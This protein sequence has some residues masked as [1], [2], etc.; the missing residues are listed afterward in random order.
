MSSG[1]RLLRP[2]GFKADPS[3]SLCQGRLRSRPAS[4]GIELACRRVITAPPP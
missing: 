1:A 2:R 3:P 4:D